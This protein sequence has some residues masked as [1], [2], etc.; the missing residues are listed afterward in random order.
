MRSGIMAATVPISRVLII[1]G[2]TSY[3]PTVVRSNG[4]RGGLWDRDR[5]HQAAGGTTQEREP[6]PVTGTQVGHEPA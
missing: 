1:A 3:S 2:A 5:L 4:L 6:L